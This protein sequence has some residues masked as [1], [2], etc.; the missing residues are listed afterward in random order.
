METRCGRSHHCLKIWLKWMKLYF[1]IIMSSGRSCNQGW[2]VRVLCWDFIGSRQLILMVL[3][4]SNCSCYGWSCTLLGQ[5]EWKLDVMFTGEQFW[6]ISRVISYHGCVIMFLS[7]PRY[8]HWPSDNEKP[9]TGD[10]TLIADQDQGLNT[11]I[12]RFQIYSL[13]LWCDCIVLEIYDYYKIMNSHL[14]NWHSSQYPNIFH[15]T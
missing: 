10:I 14:S 2:G 15:V 9:G 3:L 11:H 13:Y 1:M 6:V 12:W 5:H 4:L 8:W 7:W